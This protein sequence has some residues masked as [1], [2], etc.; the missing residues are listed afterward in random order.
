M[1]I[2]GRTVCVADEWFTTFSP[3]NT[4][5]AQGA[6][7]KRIKGKTYETL[8][9]GQACDLCDS[10]STQVEFFTEAGRGVIR[11]A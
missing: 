10:S 5:N 3:S 7:R 8:K 6:K 9:R 2:S 4:L 11:R 1:L